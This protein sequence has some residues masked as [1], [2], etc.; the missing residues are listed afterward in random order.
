M[1]F[2]GGTKTEYSILGPGGYTFLGSDCTCTSDLV[3]Y[4]SLQWKWGK[5]IYGWGWSHCCFDVRLTLRILSNITP[6]ITM[7]H[8]SFVGTVDLLS[9]PVNLLHIY[10]FQKNIRILNIKTGW[11]TQCILIH[12]SVDMS[13][14]LIQYDYAIREPVSA[15][16]FSL[17]W[18]YLTW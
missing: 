14:A 5:A 7:I 1:G 15:Y 18:I 17:T 3:V 4:G 6:G 13:V 9:G 10:Y 12:L 16:V 2:K 8:V 11:L